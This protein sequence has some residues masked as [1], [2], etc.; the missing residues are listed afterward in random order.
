MAAWTVA[1]RA[2]H[3][4][5]PPERLAVRQKLKIGRLFGTSTRFSRT[6]DPNRP[7]GEGVWAPEGKDKVT[8][9]RVE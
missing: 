1:I 4:L 5:A 7:R 6:A 2:S 8:E 3:S 9:V